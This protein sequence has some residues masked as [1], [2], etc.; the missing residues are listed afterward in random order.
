MGLS[1]TGR[2]VCLQTDH[3]NLTY[4][5]FEGSAKVKRWK[6]F[7]QEY[8]FDI[9]FIEGPKNVVA[10]G[11]SRLCFKYQE[12]EAPDGRDVQMLACF[13]SGLCV[14]ERNEEEPLQEEEV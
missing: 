5:N 12:G 4:L 2:A 11:L 7:I 8:S 13:F 3:K 6:L 10:D 9:Q 14:K 1:A